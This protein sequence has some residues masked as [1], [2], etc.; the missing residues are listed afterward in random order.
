MSSLYADGNGSIEVDDTRCKGKTASTC[1]GKGDG[2][3]CTRG[4]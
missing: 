1:I 2:I 3:Q 4:D